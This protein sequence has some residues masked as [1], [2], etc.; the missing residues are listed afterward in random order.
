[1][2]TEKTRNMKISWMLNI[3]KEAKEKKREIDKEKLFAVFA[4]K[5][6]STIRT[7]KEIYKILETT[8][9]I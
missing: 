2:G 7:A 8:G 1:M 5:Y 3:I 6:N 4:E 9:K